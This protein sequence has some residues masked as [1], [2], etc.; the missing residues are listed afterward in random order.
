MRNLQEYVAGLFEEGKHNIEGLTERIAD[1]SYDQLPHCISDSP[2]EHGP[3]LQ[4]VSRHISPLL[5]D[6]GVNQVK[7]QDWN[8]DTFP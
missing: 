3:V 6:Q 1:S 8:T 4:A 5:S 2:W 7:P